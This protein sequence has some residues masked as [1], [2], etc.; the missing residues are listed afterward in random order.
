[1]CC[2]NTQNSPTLR[3]RLLVAASHPGLFADLSWRWRARR[4]LQAEDTG[5]GQPGVGAAPTAD[6][7]QHT[8]CPQVSSHLPSLITEWL[9]VEPNMALEYNVLIVIVVGLHHSKCLR[10]HHLGTRSNKTERNVFVVLLAVINVPI[11]FPIRRKIVV[12]KQN[13]RCA[14]CGTR[15][16]PGMAITP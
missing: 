12:A 14:G 5:A 3:H 8:S 7:L 6:H 11:C 1:M 9:L 16:D 13:Y 4:H 10:G 15:I 2:S